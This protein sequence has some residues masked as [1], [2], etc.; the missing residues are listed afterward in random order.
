MAGMNI[1]ANDVPA[2]QAPTIAPS[3]RMDDQILEHRKWVPLGKSNYV[4]D[5]LRSQRNPIFK[6]AVAILKKYQL[7]QGLHD[8]FYDSCN[9]HSAV[10]GHHAAKTSCA[11][12][13]LRL[14][15][16]LQGKKKITPLLIPSIRFIKLELVYLFTTPI[17]VLGN[18]KFVGKEGRE[19]FAKEVVPESPAPKASKPKTTSLQPPNLNQHPQNHKNRITVPVHQDTSLVPS[20]T[21]SVLDLTTSQS[22]SPTVNDPL[23][24][25]TTTTTKT[26]TTTNFSP[27]LPQPQQSTIDP[28][29]LEG[30]GELEQQ[31]E[32][33]IQDKLALEERLD[34]HGSRLYNLENLNIPQKVS[35]AIDEAHDDHKNLFEA[36]QKS[37]ERDYSNQLLADLDEARRKKRKKCDLP[38]TPFGSPPPQPP[39]LPPPVGTSDALD[40]LMNDHLLKAN[41]RKDWWKLLPEEERPATPEPTWTIPSSNVSDVE[42][43]WLLHWLQPM[44]PLLRTHCLQRQET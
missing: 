43:K 8:I 38:R 5:V 7:L 26:I 44:C 9:L 34:K 42:N 17:N 3:T 16:P 36:L 33:L 30:I 4:L 28:I 32:N 39:P 35:K 13:S 18:Q 29:L 40:Y 6:V 1:P 11:S 25:S 23:L 14:T 15:M 2:D 19:V 22:D 20:M 10:L 24:T 21:T 41:I 27:P 12:D 31:M 37:L